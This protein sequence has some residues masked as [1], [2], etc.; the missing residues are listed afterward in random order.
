MADARTTR[1]IPFLYLN[2]EL[3]LAACS[4]ERKNGG[5]TRI[6]SRNLLNIQTGTSGFIST[7]D[8]DSRETS[9]FFAPSLLLSNPMSLAPKIDEIAHASH[10]AVLRSYLAYTRT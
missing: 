5:K 1:S 4:Q 7:K 9:A 6:N 2:Q 8:G 10:Q 3:S